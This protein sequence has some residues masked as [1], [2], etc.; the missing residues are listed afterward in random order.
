VDGG[1]SRLNRRVDPRPEPPRSVTHYGETSH[2]LRAAWYEWYPSTALERRY[3]PIPLCAPTFLWR[4]SRPTYVFASRPTYVFDFFHPRTGH[5]QAFPAA[6][7][8]ASQCMLVW[9]RVRMLVWAA[10]ERRGRLFFYGSRR[11]RDCTAVEGL[12]TFF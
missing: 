6:R 12:E 2:G 10:R 11:P 8:W 5:S 4:S 7:L 3:P 9:P 1:P